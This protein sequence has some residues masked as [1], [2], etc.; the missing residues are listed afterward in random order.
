MT[1]LWHKRS[2]RRGCSAEN[3]KSANNATWEDYSTIFTW[4][5]NVAL[6]WSWSQMLILAF[7]VIVLLQID[8]LHYQTITIFLAYCG[9]QDSVIHKRHVWWEIKS[10]SI[11]HVRLFIYLSMM[12]FI[13]VITNVISFSRKVWKMQVNLFFWQDYDIALSWMCFHPFG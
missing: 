10:I 7:V 5:L 1:I 3:W 6:I 8:H 4:F 11:I 13:Y 9:M 12:F 2:A